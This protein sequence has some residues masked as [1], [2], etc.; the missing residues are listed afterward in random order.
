MHFKKIS[1]SGPR[2]QYGYLEYSKTVAKQGIYYAKRHFND[3]DVLN[4]GQGS[5]QIKKGLTATKAFSG[6]SVFDTTQLKDMSIVEFHMH[7]QS[8]SNFFFLSQE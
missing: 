3:T 2:T 6:A 1:S 5:H 8:L 7:P 4:T